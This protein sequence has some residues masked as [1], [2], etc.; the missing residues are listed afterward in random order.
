MKLRLKLLQDSPDL[1]DG[2]YL[3]VT[4]IGALETATMAKGPRARWDGF[5][6]TLECSEDGV[7]WSP[8]ETFIA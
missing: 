6:A 1:A 3:C 7:L 5:V 4:H 2:A 8:V